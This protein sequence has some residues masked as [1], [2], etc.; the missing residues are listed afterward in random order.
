MLRFLAT[1][2]VFKEVSSNFASGFAVIKRVIHKFNPLIEVTIFLNRR[3]DVLDL[4]DLV[5]RRVAETAAQRQKIMQLPIPT[6]PGTVRTDMIPIRLEDV[7]FKLP[8]LNKNLFQN[9]N[10]AVE[11]GKLIA[12]V[13]QAGSGKTKLIKMLASGVS[14]TSGKVLIPSHLRCLLVSHQ[15]F[16][17]RAS[18]LQNL[19]FGDPPAVSH[20]EERHRM[21]WILD[22]LKMS[23]T[24]ELAEN[25]IEI[26]QEPV[27]EEEEDDGSC[28]GLSN[29][30]P[31]EP[32]HARWT[33]REGSIQAKKVASALH[34]WQESLSFQEKAKLHIAR[35]LIMN[36]EIMILEKPLMN[37]DD[38]EA[39]LVVGVL[40]EF[41]SN[42][43]VALSAATRDQRRPR[44][45]FYSA[46]RVELGIAMP[47]VLWKSEG[48]MV[49][50]EQP[51]HEPQDPRKGKAKPLSSPKSSQGCESP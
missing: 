46:E 2:S 10:I 32:P 12:L 25:E 7:Q 42:R 43:G 45:C 40:R 34:G 6:T 48:G 18:P 39:E 50:A 47:D 27:V 44:T 49:V 51:Q 36:P 19:F 5:D 38:R 21:M 4:K 30:A 13:G 16:L 23:R 41:V 28:C 1:I 9:V 20:P 8:A 33:P 11:Q 14:P 31:A 15:V 26:L 35:A 3:T 17:M 24:R 22:K 29:V 37:F